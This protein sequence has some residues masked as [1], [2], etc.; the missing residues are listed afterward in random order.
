MNKS[1]VLSFLFFLYLQNNIG[2]F[3]LKFDIPINSCSVM[4]RIESTD[5]KIKF[6]GVII[7][8]LKVATRCK[9]I[10]LVSLYK[11]HKS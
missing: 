11:V 10:H 1:L 6:L 3:E 2:L 5:P 8:N 4:L 9:Y 7:H